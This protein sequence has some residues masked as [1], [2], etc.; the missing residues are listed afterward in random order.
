MEA[1]VGMQ[2]LVTHYQQGNVAIGRLIRAT[3][4]AK[5][6]TITK[7]AEAIG[8]T[9]RRYSAIENGDVMIGL[10]EAGVLAEFLEIPL[11]TLWSVRRDIGTKIGKIVHVT[12]GETIQ[13]IFTSE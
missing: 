1:R 8:T 5:Q 10:L 3:R 12:R 9:R 13:I 7:C 6:I 11:E 2:D 4:E